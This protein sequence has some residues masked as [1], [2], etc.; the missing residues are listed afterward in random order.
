[1]SARYYEAVGRRKTSTARV[2]LYPGAGAIMVNE[3]QMSEYFPRETDV[4]A[5]TRPLLMTDTVDSYNISIHVVGGG[6]TGQA[7]AA[8]LGIARALCVADENLRS[9]LK[10]NGFLA[11]DA[12]AKE[13]KKFGL[14]RARKAPQ[15]TKR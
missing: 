11:R 7:N 2:R 6:L 14:K 3:R 4:L 9:V 15:Y 5:I 13:R 12:R 1:M 10:K 8:A